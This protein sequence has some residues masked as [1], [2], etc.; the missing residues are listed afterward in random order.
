MSSLNEPA[1]L[2]L[3]TVGR[4]PLNTRP[5]EGTREA[6]SSY[7]TFFAF[8]RASIFE[9]SLGSSMGLVS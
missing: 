1:L 2:D 5:H 6:S 7:E 9:M 3:D 8:S 4:R